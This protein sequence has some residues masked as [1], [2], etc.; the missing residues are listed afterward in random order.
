[1]IAY[2]TDEIFDLLGEVSCNRDVLEIWHYVLTHKKMY[3][4][5]D[6]HLFEGSIQIYLQLFI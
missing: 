2:T 1:M 3:S 5:A 4:I 6:L